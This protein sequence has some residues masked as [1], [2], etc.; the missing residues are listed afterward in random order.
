MSRFSASLAQTG[1]HLGG[2]LHPVQYL[3]VQVIGESDG[4]LI[5]VGQ[6]GFAVAETRQT[7]GNII[8]DISLRDTIGTQAPLPPVENATRPP[9][10]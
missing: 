4:D 3:L 10:L 2:G 1:S 7:Q 5:F 8:I 6:C 9:R